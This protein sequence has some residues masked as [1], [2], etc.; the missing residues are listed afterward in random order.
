MMR[1]SVSAG[2]SRVVYPAGANPYDAYALNP[3]G[4]LQAD[5]IRIDVT[6]INLDS[7]SA[8]QLLEKHQ[9]NEIH[10]LMEVRKIVA[11]RGKMH[12]PVTNSG[13]VLCGVVSKLGKNR[14]G[15]I[16]LGTRVATLVS[17]TLVPLF[18][19][20]VLGF[21]RAQHQLE[22]QGFAVLPPFA[23]YAKLPGDLPESLALSILDVCGVVPQVERLSKPGSTV[24]ILGASGKAG[25]IATFAAARAAG[26]SGR[27][28]AIVPNEAQSRALDAAPAHVIPIICDAR[29]AVTLENRVCEAT[30]GSYADVVIDCTN[31]TGVEIGAASCCRDGGTVY[32][33][34]MATRFQAAALGAELVSRDI[35]YV[36]GYG[37]LPQ[38]EERALALVRSEPGLLSKLKSE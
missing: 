11:E 14:N 21:N 3:K 25:L 16:P 10:F 35:Q 23:K 31:C 36:I 8:N 19:E 12:N 1:L 26:S 37:L 38:A 33:F 27:I 29:D 20:K 6:S 24:A 2:L 15:E 32:F 13:G 34:N 18:V 17:N 5:E 30:Q 22:V 4:E 9:G 28:L 7:T